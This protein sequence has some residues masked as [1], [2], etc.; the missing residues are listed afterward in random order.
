MFDNEFWGFLSIVG[1]VIL[2]FAILG[3]IIA[4]IA[5]GVKLNYTQANIVEAYQG[6]ELIYKGKAAFINISS[7]GMTTTLT[8]YNNLFPIEKIEKVY[9]GQ[10]I[11]VVPGK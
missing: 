3:F 11:K 10:D 6:N 9:S 1:S 4:G 8:I 7:G 5:V 2:G